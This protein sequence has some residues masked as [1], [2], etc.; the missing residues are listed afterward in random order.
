MRIQVTAEQWLEAIAKKAELSAHT[1]QEVLNRYGVEPQSTLPRRRALRVR[2]II[3][4]G[5]KD[6]SNDDGPFD[7]TFSFGP[8]L[9]AILS[10][11]NFRGKSTILNV[12]QGAIRGDVADRVKPDV[13]RWLTDLHVTFEANGIG[14]RLLITKE[15]GQAEMGANASFC[16]EERVEW[17]SLY[18]GPV[19]KPLERAVEDVMLAEFNFT[20]FH[21]YNDR[22]GSHTHGWPAIASALFVVGPGKAVFGEVLADAIP[23]R[24]LQMFMGLPWVSTYTTATTAAKRLKSARSERKTGAKGLQ[25]R[26]RA[27]LDGVETSLASVRKRVRT[28]YDRNEL[29][30]RILEQDRHLLS[31]RTR[32]DETGQEAFRLDRQLRG[33]KTVLSDTR[34][35]LQQLKDDRAAG[36][37]LRTLRPVC[38]PSCDTSID[39]DRHVQAGETAT[40]ALCGARQVEASDEEALRLEELQKDVDDVA[41][42]VNNLN[43]QAVKAEAMQRQ[44]ETSLAEAVQTARDLEREMTTEGAAELELEIRGLE[45]Q[46]DQLVALITAETDDEAQEATQ[47]HDEPVLKAAES[48]TKALYDNLARE[49]LRDLSGEITR[50]SRA[51]GV[52]NLEHMEWGTGGQMRI[53]QGGAPTNFS[54]LSP[55]EN[56]RV[57]IAAALAVIEVSRQ[58]RYGRHPGLLVLDSPAAQ[59]MAPDDFAALLSSVQDAVK[60][61]DDIQILVG[62]LAK[63]ALLQVVPHDH[64]KH[65][66]GDDFLF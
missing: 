31:Q 48:I 5:I 63:P 23:L 39:H 22:D 7:Q 51:F 53:M 42:Y 15:A 1:V 62:A 21:A 56:L 25:D 37:V 32:V 34:R 12:I 65:A 20:R 36:V 58:R 35:A 19:G 38:C 4:K 11:Q 59:E 26:L 66:E 55:G 6:G 64:V 60:S 46:R 9:W 47:T 50:L 43:K 17:L 24:L 13:W 27:R 10:D 16:R 52:Q 61:A 44:A 57:R 30:A 28:G 45:A 18:E 2:N 29:R 3:L 14:Y 8:G 54:N 33:A 41:A 49:I 40:C